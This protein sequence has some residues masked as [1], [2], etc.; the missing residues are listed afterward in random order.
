[1]ERGPSSSPILATSHTDDESPLRQFMSLQQNTLLVLGT[2]RVPPVPCPASNTDDS[3]AILSSYGFSSLAVGDYVNAIVQLRPDIALVPGDVI[4]EDQVAVKVVGA[5][6]KEKMVERTFSWTKALMYAIDELVETGAHGPAL[7]A[8]VLPID[9]EMQRQY[10]LEHHENHEWSSKIRGLGLYD[11]ASVEA[12]P[13]EMSHL[14]RLLLS[15]PSNPQ[16][17]LRAIS[18]GIDLFT[19]PIITAATD[20][21]IALTF[22][23]PVLPSDLHKPKK[24][25][26][27]I[28]LWDSLHATQL[29][30]LEADCRCYT[31]SSHHR[32]FIHHLLSVKEMLA[33]VLLQVHNHCII[34]EFFDGARRSIRD[35]KLEYDIK[36]FEELFDDA[37]PVSNGHGPRCVPFPYFPCLNLLLRYRLVG[38]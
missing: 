21:G 31:C 20:A 17:I 37:L 25:A 10:L 32:A 6:R 26:L 34:D 11:V 23:F 4:L 3:I 30:P 36:L 15:N 16:A 2:R 14:P 12:V 9:K 7:Y 13:S 27:G 8:P 18:K 33:W 5:K 35:G 24:S 22:R 19:L 29:K 1:M 38:R 28:N